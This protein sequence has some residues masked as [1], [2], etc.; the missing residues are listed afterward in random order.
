[1]KFR[2]FRTG[3]RVW[4]VHTDTSDYDIVV[5]PDEGERLARENVIESFKG[6]NGE[7]LYTNEDGRLFNIIVLEQAEY[8]AWEY[9]T[10]MLH[11]HT[12]D[13]IKRR[14]DRIRLFIE[15]CNKYK[16]MR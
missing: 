12:Y 13:E 1:M 2:G 8:N 16:Y 11:S 10:A 14:L 7:S 3:S 9:A 6:S 15:Y 5:L 4:G